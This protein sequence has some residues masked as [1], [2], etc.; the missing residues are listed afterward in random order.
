MGILRDILIY[1]PPVLFAITVHEFSHGWVAKKVG[2]DTADL[3]GRLTLNP[4][5]HIDLFGSIILPLILIF[6]GSG[7][8]IAWAKP[9]PINPMLFRKPRRDT[10]LVSA[11]GPAS[12]LVLAT[13]LGYLLIS[14]AAI[15]NAPTLSPFLAMLAYGV[16]INLVLAF[17]NLLPIPPL[18]G[19]RI[20]ASAF[21]LRSRVFKYDRYGFLIILA[22]AFLVPMLVGVSPLALWIN[23]FVDKVAF[24]LFGS[25]V[26]EIVRYLYY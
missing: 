9:V 1:G 14:L 19:S 4:I 3:A 8:V 12:N 20:V 15:G 26:G 21:N 17:F 25:H 5:A 16:L 6:S 18:D 10:I 24:I 2:D 23:F 22:L 13:L 11:A 7:F